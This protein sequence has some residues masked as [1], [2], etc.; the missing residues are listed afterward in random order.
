MA[1]GNRF[2]FVIETETWV[3]VKTTTTIFCKN[4]NLGARLFSKQLDAVENGNPILF[5]PTISLMYEPDVANLEKNVEQIA[6]FAQK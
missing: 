3:R 1:L 6:E 5:S 2:C 4:A